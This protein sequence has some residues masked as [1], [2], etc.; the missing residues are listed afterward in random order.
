ME[1]ASV[2]WL[3]HLCGITHTL[4]CLV[5]RSCS[6]TMSEQRLRVLVKY[7]FRVAYLSFAQQIVEEYSEKIF[8][9]RTKKS[10]PTLSLAQQVLESICANDKKAVYEHIVK[11][12]V[13]VNAINWQSLSGDSLRVASSSNLNI[14]SQAENQLIE[15]IQD[16][17]SALHLACLTSD[18][19][20]V[21]LLLQLGA[22]INASDSGGR[23]PLHCCIIRGKTAAAKLLILR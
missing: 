7:E 14:A 22:D 11:S 21:E 18:I 10:H 3:H 4:N 23:T 2:L 6:D 16:G 8:I 19:G 15:D 5:A 1:I 20:M 12:D 13:G 9:S 17:S